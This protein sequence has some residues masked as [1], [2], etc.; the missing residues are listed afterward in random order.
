MLQRAISRP[1]G[2][3]CNSVPC[4]LV[5]RHGRKATAKA[6]VWAENVWV[7]EQYGKVCQMES[8]GWLPIPD[9]MQVCVFTAPLFSAF[10]ALA[11]YGLVKEVGEVAGGTVFW[12]L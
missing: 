12:E 3:A 9:A 8:H 7:R 10:C 1:G 6:G 4:R 11:C 2:Q 5:D